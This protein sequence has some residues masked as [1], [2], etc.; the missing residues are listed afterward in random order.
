MKC[1]VFLT[2]MAMG[3]AMGMAA[4]MMMP[5]KKKCFGKMNKVVKAAEDIADIISDAIGG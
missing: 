3:A 2:G 1:S 5:K 4:G